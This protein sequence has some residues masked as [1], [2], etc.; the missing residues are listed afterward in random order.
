MVELLCLFY[1][2]LQSNLD[3]QFRFFFVFVVLSENVDKLRV[4][5]L[6]ILQKNFL[7]LPT[8]LVLLELVAFVN[9][10]S[11]LLEVRVWTAVDVETTS[12]FEVEEFTHSCQKSR[13]FLEKII[14]IQM[15]RLG[16]LRRLLW[17]SFSQFLLF[18]LLRL[19][20][21]HFLN[22]F[23]QELVLPL[24]LLYLHLQQLLPLHL[25]STQRR[26]R[27]WSIR[28]S[29]QLNRLNTAERRMVSD[30]RSGNNRLR[31]VHK[32]LLLRTGLSFRQ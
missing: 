2:C 11:Q 18:S 9:R 27:L 30:I 24:Q 12:C 23:L 20:H 14:D 21:R 5:L 4:F 28:A 6:L 22:F 25:T 32:L 3:F 26:W 8:H 15:Q 31:F 16:M 7:H 1:H 29:R 13:Y 17:S 10:T 19:L